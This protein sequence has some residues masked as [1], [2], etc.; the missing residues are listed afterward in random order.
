MSVDN[1]VKMIAGFT[2]FYPTLSRQFMHLLIRRL[3]IVMAG[4]AIWGTGTRAQAQIFVT[5]ETGGTIGEY[6]LDGS[7]INSSLVSGLSSPGL[8]LA[9]SGT[10]LFVGTNGSWVQEYTT[11][12]AP[13]ATPLITFL[14]AVN[15]I[16]ISGS[17]MFVVNSSNVSEFTLS[18]APVSNPLV[19]NLHGNPVFIAASSSD[20]FVANFGSGTVSEY[21]LSGSLVNADLITVS[22]PDGIVVS[23]ND[24]FIA[25]SDNGTI[26]EYT[27]SGTVVKA[28]LVTGLQAPEALALAGS[29]LYVVNDFNS[30]A[31]YT[32]SGSIVNSALVTGL[33]SPGGLVVIAAPE[34]GS[35]S[36]L[37]LGLVLLMCT[38]AWMIP[39]KAK[40]NCTCPH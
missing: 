17:D 8:G 6:S 26:G 29:D 39:R 38:A 32:V 40:R 25:S 33:N 1:G 12:G 21:T 15:G 4:L 34:P 30:I 11:S 28:S 24:L 27:I 3:V 5:D 18:G 9:L 31:E 7:T 16:A 14:P 2:F 36:L 20:I 10:N 37:F 23:G 35:G 19:T 13:V 22:S